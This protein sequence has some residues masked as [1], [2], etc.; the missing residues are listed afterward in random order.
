MI[1][2]LGLLRYHSSKLILN[3]SWHVSLAQQE[4]FCHCLWLCFYI[5]IFRN[6]QLVFLFVL[7][8][9]LINDLFLPCTVNSFFHRH[10]L[11]I[12]YISECR[13]PCKTC[14]TI[15]SLWPR[16]N[17]CASQTW[18][19]IGSVIVWHRADRRPWALTRYVKLL[20]PHPPG[21][22]RTFSPSLRVN[23][24]DMH[25]KKKHCSRDI[26]PKW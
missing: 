22:T 7:F 9:V 25:N 24:P 3:S 19:N 14:N 8:H 26:S 12:F 21:T 15:G 1:V 10:S 23:D 6:K 17:M 16:D 5:V 18:V 13:M 20:V 2:N 11:D 4:H